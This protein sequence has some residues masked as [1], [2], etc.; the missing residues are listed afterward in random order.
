MSR[1]THY[2]RNRDT[3]LTRSW[4]AEVP[5]LRPAHPGWA[6]KAREGC[7]GSRGRY[8]DPAIPSDVILLVVLGIMNGTDEPVGCVFIS[9][10]HEDSAAVDRLQQELQA[11]G[12]RVWRDISDLQPGENRQYRIREVISR[13]AKMFLACFSQGSLAREKSYQREELILAIQEL[14][15]R[16]RGVPWLIPIRFDDC[17][18]PEL[19]IGA[20]QTLTDLNRVDLFGDKRDEQM[21]RLVGVVQRIMRS[22]GGS[23]LHRAQPIVLA[24]YCQRLAASDGELRF[25]LLAGDLPPMTYS[26]LADSFRVSVPGRDLAADSLLNVARRWPRML[27]TGLPGMGKSTAVQQL[28]ARWAGDPEAL[29]SQC[30]CRSKPSRADAR[31]AALR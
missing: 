16:D 19:P 6:G 5:L 14:R 7:G 9:Y 1:T 13:N 8:A 25:S 26:S 29:R 23:Q 28:E 12:F 4:R 11:A 30:W 21:S 22:S 3:S 27:L 17:V 31:A 2:Y 18:V 15:Q 20:G 10:V 24:E